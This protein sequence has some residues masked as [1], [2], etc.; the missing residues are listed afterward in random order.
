MDTRPQISVVVPVFNGA[1]ALRKVFS[2]IEDVMASINRCFEVIFVDDGSIDESWRLILEL[3]RDHGVVVR[4]FRL[5]RNSGQ[6]AATYCGL[7]Q[8]RGDWVVTLDDDLQPHP[9]EIVKLW[10]RAQAGHADVIYGVYRSLK[11]GLSHRVGT[12]LFR[13]LL[14]R[15]SPSF[16][17]GSS[18]RMIR[19]D[20]LQALPRHPGPW[21][22]VDPVLA[23]RTSEVTSVVVEHSPREAGRS[24]YSLTTLIALAWTLLITYSTVPLRLMA[25]IGFASASVSF[26]LGLYY[27][28]RKITVGA[29]VGFSASIVTT[30]F[31]SGLILLSLGILGEYISRIHSMGTGEPAF[32]VKAT[33]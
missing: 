29:Q 33:V 1:N 25:A 5:A 32:T 24:A 10:E 11:H 18:F 8:A 6:Q 7:L 30:T 15:V 4:G 12:R 21:V 28:V 16:P 2:G 22:F 3:R 14:R 26:A 23:W 19:S 31:S 27:L 20:V 17:D 9:R 13:M